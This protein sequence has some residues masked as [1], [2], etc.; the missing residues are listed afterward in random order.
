MIHCIADGSIITGVTPKRDP[1]WTNCPVCTRRHEIGYRADLPIPAA[2]SAKAKSRVQYK[3]DF[4]RGLLDAA[5]FKVWREDALI[6]AHNLTVEVKW[7]SKWYEYSWAER[8]QRA[9]QA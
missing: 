1:E 7:Q 4:C 6:Q 3:T 9:L 2:K 8:A 5:K